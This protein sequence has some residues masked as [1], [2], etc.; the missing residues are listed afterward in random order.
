M[1]D[2]VGFLGQRLVVIKPRG[3]GIEAEVELVLPAELKAGARE[4][5]VA[6]LLE[7]YDY[8][9][10]VSPEKIEITFLGV[11]GGQGSLVQVVQS[12]RVSRAG[13]TRTPK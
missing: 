10:A 11:R 1:R 3:L 7:R 13:V 2:L 12:S 5:V 6:Q 9:L 4:C 8:V